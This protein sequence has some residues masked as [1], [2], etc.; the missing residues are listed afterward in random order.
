MTT[1]LII[2]D[3][4]LQRE[5]LLTI[6]SEEGYNVYSASSLEEASKIINEIFPEIILTDL[7]LGSQN[8]IEI[9]NSLPEEPFRPAVIVITAFGTISSAVNAIK[10]GAFDYLTK[11]LDKEVLLVTIRKAEER[12]NLIKEN[13]ML[14]K[15]LYEKFKIEGII[16]KSRKMLQVLDIVKKATPTNATVLIYGESGTGKELIARAIHYNSP[17]KDKP[18]IAINCAAI[19]ETLIESELFGYEPGAFTGANTRKIGLIESANRGTLFLDEI[20]EIPLSTQSKLLRVLQDKEVRRI[21]CK[22]TN[23]VDVRIIAAT[24][25]NLSEQ[26]EKNKFRED[27]YYRLKVITVEIPPLRERK[28]DIPELVHF[29]IEKYSK[30]FGKRVTGI[31]DKALEALLN[32]SWPGNI[33]EL[34]SVIER[35][36]II[37]E[38]DKITFNDIQDELRGVTPKSLFDINIPDEGINYEEIEKELIKKALIKSNFVIAKAAR[39]LGMSYDTFWYRLKKFGLSDNIREMT[40]NFVK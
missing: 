11:P 15:E 2:D 20:A 32:Y 23:K 40:K 1:L 31:E 38:K 34:E 25:K 3:E 28:E 9:L 29:F 8:G 22:D 6:L 21:G 26:V 24:N 14:R 13:L 19:P 4:P 5:I 12:M 17:R 7:K 27:L 10:Q 37:C 18:F 33:R 35:A 36:I 30:E 16:G 39:L